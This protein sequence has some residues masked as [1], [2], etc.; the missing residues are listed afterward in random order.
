MT[1]P[2]PRALPHKCQVCR[3]APASGLFIGWPGH[4]PDHPAAMRGLRLAV[5]AG[6]D[7]QARAV[8]RAIIKARA[9]WPW[10]RSGHTA[11]ARAAIER[12]VADLTAGPDPPPLTPRAS[13]PPP[14]R[15]DPAQPSLI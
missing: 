3:D 13:P 8:A 1:A 15:P 4:A 6:D 14:A 5:C 11:E 7:C 2:Q 10:H 9:P 12:I